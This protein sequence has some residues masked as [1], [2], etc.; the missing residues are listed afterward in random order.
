VTVDGERRSEDRRSPVGDFLLGSLVG[1]GDEPLPYA[2]LLRIAGEQGLNMSS[3]LAWAAH[4]EEAGLIEQRSGANGQGRE[5]LLTRHGVEIASN[6]RRRFARRERW[7]L[8]P[9]DIA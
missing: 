4:A 6:N 8:P 1:R 5:L 7:N 2:E 3:V 9:D